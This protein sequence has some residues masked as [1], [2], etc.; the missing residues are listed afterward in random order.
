MSVE[1]RQITI[2]MYPQ[3]FEGW[4]KT[5]AIYTGDDRKSIHRY[6]TRNPGL[7]YAAFDGNK[8]VG[9]ILGDHDGR[10]GK[11]NRL[12]VLPEYRRRGIAT[13]LVAKSIKALKIE[14]IERI[15]IAIHKIN[16]GAQEFWKSLHFKEVDTVVLWGSN[17]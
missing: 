10:R 5:G 17:I 1:I 3:L 13:E 2:D 12:F 6:L 14:G 11:L 7:S 4:Q 15:W 16:K 9:A 8:M